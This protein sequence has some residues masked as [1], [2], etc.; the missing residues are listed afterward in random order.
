MPLFP[1]KSM[2]QQCELENAAEDYRTAVRAEQ[3][4]V[5]GK[6]LYIAAFPGSKYIPFAALNQVWSKNTGISVTGTCGK[7]I[8]MVCLRL[9]YDGEFYQNIL[10]EKQA[11]VDKVLE[12]IRACRPD[13]P[14]DRNTAPRA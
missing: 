5:S 11:G 6:A 2:S 4:R 12:R 10:F 9:R 3:Y 8:P 7:Q 14:V 13:V 1:I